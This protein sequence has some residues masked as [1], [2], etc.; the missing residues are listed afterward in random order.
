M[1]AIGSLASVAP[2]S[3]SQAA[4]ASAAAADDR[5]NIVLIMTDDMTAADLSVMPKTRSL[6]GA[7]GMTFSEGLSLH[8]LCCPAR[9]QVLTG[10]Y[11]QNNGVYTNSG[12]YG[13]YEKLREPD[14]TLASWLEDSGYRTALTGKFLNGY[15][16]ERDGRP[17]GW[18]YWNPTIKGT[19]NYFDYTVAGDG[20]PAD[21]GGKYVTQH[22]ADDTRG[23]IEKW[24]P[25][26]TPFFIWASYVAPHKTCLSEL[27]GL[28]CSTLPR[29]EPQY[30]NAF[31]GVTNPA[32]VKKS[33][34]ERDVSDK[35]PLLRKGK[36][37]TSKLERLY[38]ARIRSLASVDDAVADTVAA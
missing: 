9:A 29:P 16:W 25:Q 31:T 15:K 37:S 27:D 21:S 18:T 35:P 36:R 14:N 22:V 1:A 7:Q 13:G 30:E 19:Y 34:N 32:R 24:A 12:V 4:Q 17:T 6:L 23:L 33:Y 10:Q 2:Q 38:L 26:P 20:K 11:A 5:P 28:N 3:I 8:P